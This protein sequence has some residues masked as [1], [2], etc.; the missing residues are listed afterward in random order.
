MGYALPAS[1]GAAFATNQSIICITG[2]GGIQM[3]IQELAT[4]KKHNLPIKIFL[5]S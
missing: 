2:D 3:N 1:I 5:I 4:I